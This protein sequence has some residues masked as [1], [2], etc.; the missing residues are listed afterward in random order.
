M[1]WRGITTPT[2]SKNA[3]KAV[4][5]A[6]KTRRA[7]NLPLPAALSGQLKLCAT[8]RQLSSINRNILGVWLDFVFPYRTC[9]SQIHTDNEVTTNIIMLLTCEGRNFHFPT[10]GKSGQAGTRLG[11]DGT[12]IWPGIGP[13]LTTGGIARIVPPPKLRGRG[14]FQIRP[15]NTM[16][17]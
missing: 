15:T 16:G 10:G 6:L 7:V 8:Y 17:Q 14:A 5:T 2:Y 11:F 4:E 13:A 3:K 1:I 12:R 9:D